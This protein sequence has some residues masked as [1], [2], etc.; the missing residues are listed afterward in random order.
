MLELQVLWNLTRKISFCFQ[1]GMES[2]TFLEGLR[3]TRKPLCSMFLFRNHEGFQGGISEGS[4]EL[5]PPLKT[6]LRLQLQS[7]SLGLGWTVTSEV[8]GR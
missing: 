2:S 1:A 8:C 6:E 7:V 3:V 4:Q 5:R